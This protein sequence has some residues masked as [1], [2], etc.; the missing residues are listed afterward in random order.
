[1][2]WGGFYRQLKNTRPHPARLDGEAGRW[3]RGEVDAAQPEDLIHHPY[4]ADGV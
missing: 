2:L 3:L 4:E 1:M